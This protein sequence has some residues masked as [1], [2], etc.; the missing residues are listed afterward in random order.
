MLFNTMI[1]VESYH[2]LHTNIRKN[3]R[4]VQVLHGCRQFVD[5]YVWLIP[6]NE[7]NPRPYLFLILH[8]D[9]SSI[10]SSGTMTNPH[11]PYGVGYRR[12]ARAYN[13]YIYRM[14]QSSNTELITKIC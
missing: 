5:Y 10:R 7:R 2:L 11:G 6:Y 3:F 12:A 9:L 1:R 4:Y 13:I 14:M 8:K